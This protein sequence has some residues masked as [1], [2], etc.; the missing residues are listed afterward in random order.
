VFEVL[1]YAEDGNG[2][3]EEREQAARLYPQQ[4]TLLSA[5]ASLQEEVDAT[6]TPTPGG[7]GVPGR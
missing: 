4:T 5:A 2:D 3:G 1:I 7:V 6:L